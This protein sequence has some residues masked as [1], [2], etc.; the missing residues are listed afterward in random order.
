MNE[1]YLL[2][3][4]LNTARRSFDPATKVGAVITS[5]GGRIQAIAHNRFPTL[6]ACTP[7]R[8]NDRPTKLKYMV[9]AEMAA[10]HNAAHG[11]EQLSGSTLHLAA[12]D[13]TGLIWGGPPCM[14]CALALIDLG[15]KRIVTYPGKPADIPWKWRE[16]VA[17][18]KEMLFEAR[19]AYEEFSP[20]TE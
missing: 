13:D 19:V 4:A 15:I 10:V 6:L 20:D 3:L 18:A 12:T 7:E 9:H 14:A 11:R 1:Q 17:E 8:L 16:N 2:R 5:S